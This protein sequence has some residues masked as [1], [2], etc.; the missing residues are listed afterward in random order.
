M[1]NQIVDL[2]FSKIKESRSWNDTKA[3][4]LSMHQIHVY[5]AKFPSFLVRK[6]INHIE[7]KGKEII[8]VGD[9]FCGCGTTALE[10]RLLKK[11]FWGC[12]INP[13]A[14]LISKV[15]RE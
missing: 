15:K 9:I 7:K 5:P 11:E 2:N 10:A 14:T 8:T 1:I 4:E 13:I 6:T 3:K 12:D